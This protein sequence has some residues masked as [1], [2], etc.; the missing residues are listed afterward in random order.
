MK[1]GRSETDL[2]GIKVFEKFA[3]LQLIQKARFDD[4]CGLKRLGPLINGRSDI[5]DFDEW[6]RLDLTYIEEWSFW[7]DLKILARTLPVVLRGHGAY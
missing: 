7:T 6:M 4:I 2:F 5:H 1:D 3:A